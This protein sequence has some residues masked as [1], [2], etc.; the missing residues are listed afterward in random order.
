MSLWRRGA[1]VFTTAQLHSS[2][3]GV[4]EIRDGEDLWQWSPLEIWLNAFS[5]WTIPQKQFIIMSNYSNTD[6]YEFY[7]FKVFKFYLIF[8]T[9]VIYNDILVFLS[10]CSR[11]NIKDTL[12]AWNDFKNKWKSVWSNVFWYVKV[13]IFWNFTQYIIQWGETRMLQKCSSDKFSIL[14]F[15]SRAPTHHSFTFNLRF[16]YELKHKIPLS[17]TAYGIFDFRFRFVFTK[18]Y[19][20]V[21]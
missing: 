5:R 1:V 16:S 15:V 17:K 9:D 6:F 4:L 14:F 7:R 18:V 10:S 3:P 11:R 19:C 20:F 8:R 12:K 2:K 21:H 13:C